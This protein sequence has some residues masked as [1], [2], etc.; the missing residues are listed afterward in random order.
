[1]KIGIFRFSYQ[2][3]KKIRLSYD[4]F[5]KC[6]QACRLTVIEMSRENFE[7]ELNSIKQTTVNNIASSNIQMS[8]G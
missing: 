4:V 2:S 5:A 3:S 8:A 1:M 7:K 6:R